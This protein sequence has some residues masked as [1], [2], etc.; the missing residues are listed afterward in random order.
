[1]GNR[2]WTDDQLL[3][4]VTRETSWRGV[5]REL[6]LKPTST[7]SLRAV[8]RRATHLGLDTSHLRRNRKWSDL[9]LRDAVS[10]STSWREV[11]DLIGLSPNGGTAVRLKGHAVRLGLAIAHL[12]EKTPLPSLEQL[13]LESQSAEL[14]NAAPT[15]AAAWFALRGLPVAFPSEPQEYDLLV[16]APDGIYRVQ[17]KST[18]SFAPNGNWQVGIAQR[19]DKHGWR[20][21]YDPSNID[22]FVVIN[23]DGDLYLIPIEAVAGYTAIYLGAYGDYKVGD[24]SSLLS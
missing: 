21:P 19:P 18:T 2:T 14:R 24:V 4:A 5:L 17:V 7:G 12:E 23:G 10:R 20:I 22:V 15:V 6:G 13:T 9:Q 3:K 1:M 8:Q 11:A 16:T